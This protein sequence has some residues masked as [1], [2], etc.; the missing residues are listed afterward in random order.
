MNQI[1]K[2]NLIVSTIDM[3]GHFWTK[4]GAVNLEIR[5]GTLCMVMKDETFISEIGKS[6]ISVFIDNKIVDVNLKNEK[7]FIIVG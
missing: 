5:R 4:H 6:Q 1:K 2:G 7:Q 3:W